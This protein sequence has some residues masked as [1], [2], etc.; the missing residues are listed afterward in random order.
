MSG[1]DWEL[2]DVTQP[3]DERTAVWPGDTP[4]SRTWVMQLAAGDSCD[5]STIRTSVHAG[6]HA[7][8]PRH[9][10]AGGAG[11]A[12]VPLEAYIGPCRVLSVTPQGDPPFVP[13]GEIEALAGA[14]VERLLL[15]TRRGA[16]DPA[17]FDERFCAL[18]PAAAE[19]A[20]ALGLSLIGLDTPSMDSF[21]SKDLP[22]HKILV[23]GGV[24]ILENLDLSRAADG[25]WELIALP[26]KIRG[27]D[28][29][30]VRAVLRR[31]HR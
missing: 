26:L 7:D 17:V 5:V 27:A 1:P 13:A 19:A 6:T 23:R 20:V 4:F 24:A 12:E 9:F 8:A 2:V 3:L 10:V 22:A 18:G 25:D 30:P 11:A 29:T 28:A 14:G 21:A 16:L 15:R 31:P